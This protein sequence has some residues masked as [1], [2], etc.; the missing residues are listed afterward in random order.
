M[1][2]NPD[3]SI[4]AREVIFRRKDSRPSFNFNES[5]VYQ[6]TSQKHLGIILE[7]CLT[8]EEHLRLVFSKINRTIGLLCKLQCLIPRSALLTI[9]KTFFPPWSWFHPHVDIIYKKA[10]NSFSHQKIESVQYN[11]CLAITGAIK[12]ISKEELH[13][14]LGLEPFQLRRWFRKL[15]YF[16]KFYKNESPQY[17]FKLVP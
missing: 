15:C 1:S 9:Y 8:F 2:F 6:I 4:Q 12:G 13:D 10:C 11:A 5:I 16:H 3:R 14:E 17:L 7:N